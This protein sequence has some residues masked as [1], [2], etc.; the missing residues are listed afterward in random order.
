MTTRISY[1]ISFLT[2]L[3]LVFIGARFLLAPLSAELAYGIR[4]DTRTDFSFH[5]IKG[6]RDLFSG[7]LLML[8]VLFNQ[9]KALAIT[10]L[11]ATVVPFGDM[12][13]VLNKNYNNIQQAI[14]HIIAVLICIIVGPVLLLK[15]KPLKKDV[16]K[17]TVRIL[18]SA[19]EGGES[20]LEGNI[21]PGDKTP[22]HYHTLFSETF[23]ILEGSLE[24]GKNKQVFHLKAGDS[25][26]IAPYETH[27]FNNKSGVECL[28]RT[29]LR[30]GNKDFENACLILK[31]LAA[32]GMANASG[33]PK[34]ISDL[35]IFIY[36]NNS[37]MVGIAK[38][39]EPLFQYLAKRAIGKGRLAE[40][41]KAYC[42]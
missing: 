13:I 4:L 1:F 42:Q 16:A 41:Q 10:L 39:A 15:R 18:R 37:R 11:V 38:I 34:N 29:I 9:R 36:L 27:Y 25:L 23:E 28:V 24:V 30:P 26:T 21:S 31:G 6:I 5:Y 14:P 22:W 7:L 33:I 32:D 20:V 3:G 8:L 17:G 19:D 2:G 12:L 40:L 35:A